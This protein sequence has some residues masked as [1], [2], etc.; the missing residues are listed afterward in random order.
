M[1]AG[2]LA[3]RYARAIFEI[4]VETGKYEPLGNEVA[5]IANAMTSSAEL[6]DVLINP[7]FQR[8][9]RRKVLDK[10]LMRLGVSKTTRNFC[11]LL[12][13]RERIHA[14]PDIA[15]ELTVMIDAKAGR[16]KA[17]VSSA[18]PLSALQEQQIKQSLERISGKTV[19]V[20]KREDR[21]L[22]GGVVAQLGDVEYDGSL[23]T[24]LNRMR[25]SLVK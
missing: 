18:Q 11:H 14:L 15:R 19:Q 4:G 23:R 17:T 21:D 20:T 13:D 16:V 6:T 5:D 24:Q 2:S 22:L 8:S 9:Q 12:L 1:I 7:I 10:I 25:D 3:R